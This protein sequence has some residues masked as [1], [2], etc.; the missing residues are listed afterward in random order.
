MKSIKENRPGN[1]KLIIGILSSSIDSLKRAHQIITSEFGEIDCESDIVSF[2]YT[3]YYNVEMGN[4]I[5]RR[6]VSFKKLIFPGD[7][8][9]TKR[10]TIEMENAEKACNK[11]VMNLDPGYLTLSSLILASTK[12]ACYRVY[13]DEGIYAQPM[14]HFRKGGFVPFEFTYP[15]YADDKTRSFFNEVR[16]I[17][18]M[19]L[20]DIK[21]AG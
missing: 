5:L 15:D 7:L 9:R 14:L 1:V 4:N 13:L 2:N 16:G 3:D 20:K 18:H 6:F 17:Y 12:E 8:W 19:Q 10:R 11:R 21:A